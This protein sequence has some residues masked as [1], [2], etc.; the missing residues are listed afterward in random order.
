ME[1]Q[2]RLL[3]F[4]ELI[5]LLKRY[6]FADRLDTIMQ[7]RIFSVGVPMGLE[8]LTLSDECREKYRNT[9]WEILWPLPKNPST[10]PQCFYAADSLRDALRLR[11]QADISFWSDPSETLPQYLKLTEEYA[12]ETELVD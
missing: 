2:F 11:P 1:P 9:W 8:M 3:P 5:L 12:E 6:G 7:V 10:L 4:E